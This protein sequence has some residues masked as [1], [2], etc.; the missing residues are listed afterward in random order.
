MT[1][2][3]WLRYLQTLSPREA[4]MCRNI[5]E[6]CTSVIAGE[7]LRHLES[8]DEE[9]AARIAGD[10]QLRNVANN[11][12]MLIEDQE[13]RIVAIEEGEATAPS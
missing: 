13:A 6:R 12:R 2:A 4:E 7:Q 3:D 8:E 5:V 9:Q 10:Q 11:D 1:E